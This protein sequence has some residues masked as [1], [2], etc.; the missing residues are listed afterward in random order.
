MGLY[1]TL[2][3]LLAFILGTAALLGATARPATAG[4]SGVGD[5]SECL[6]EGGLMNEMEGR[7]NDWPRHHVISTETLDSTFD[8]YTPELPSI[9][10][11]TI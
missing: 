9:P 4:A 1:R 7:G 3:L 8:Q 10:M 2:A 5:G 6:V 11:D